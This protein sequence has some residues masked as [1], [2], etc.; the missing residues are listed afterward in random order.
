MAAPG[1]V[2]IS[3]HT[4][5]PQRSGGDNEDSATAAAGRGGSRP[6][7]SAAPPAVKWHSAPEGATYALP[8]DSERKATRLKLLS[9]A[10]PHM[11]AFHVSTVAFFL[12]FFSTFAAAALLPILRDQLNLTQTDVGNA[13]IA[14]VCGAI[15]SR[16]LIGS[17][18]DAF[19]PRASAAAL[20]MLTAPAVFGLALVTNAA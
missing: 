17:L 1:E 11:R 20:L 5:W 13:G 12:C 4:Q 9:A 14:S 7:P 18:T 8:V 6:G 15:G 19:G 2:S 10:R 16:I 3:T